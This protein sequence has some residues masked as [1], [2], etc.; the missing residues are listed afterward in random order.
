VMM[1]LKNYKIKHATI[2]S[3]GV[4]LLVYIVFWAVRG[5]FTDYN[6][7]SFFVPS[8]A[9][10]MHYNTGGLDRM[11]NSQLLG[12]A[13]K[14]GF[15]FSALAANIGTGGVVGVFLSAMVSFLVIGVS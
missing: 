6:L 14:T 12:Q 10:Y 7:Y 13:F 11:F 2:I 3:L 4:S 9:G 5:N 8:Y 1:V 15:D